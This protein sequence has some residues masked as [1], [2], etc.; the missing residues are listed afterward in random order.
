MVVGIPT[1]PSS[2]KWHQRTLLSGVCVKWWRRSRF[3]KTEEEAGRQ[4]GLEESF[5]HSKEAVNAV[6]GQKGIVFAAQHACVVGGLESHTAHAQVYVPASP[7][8]SEARVYLCQL[9]LR[10][11]A[12]S[13]L[14][15]KPSRSL[16]D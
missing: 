13:T 14:T 4:N 15:S 5:V 1:S 16:T 10:D 2:V 12:S 9:S 6:M 8:L 11:S 7:L 3:H